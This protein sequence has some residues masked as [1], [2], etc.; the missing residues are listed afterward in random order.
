MLEAGLKCQK[1]I[2][3]EDYF[4]LFLSGKGLVLVILID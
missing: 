3:I 1:S 4:R 2:G